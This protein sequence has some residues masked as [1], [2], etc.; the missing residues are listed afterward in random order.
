MLFLMDHVPKISQ[1]VPATN[2]PF[3]AVIAGQA[4]QLQAETN[5]VFFGKNIDGLDTELG[6]RR[7]M[8]MKD[9]YISML[10]S[11]VQTRRDTIGQIRAALNSRDTKKAEY[12]SHSLFGISGQIG[13]VRVPEDALQLESALSAIGEVNS[14]ELMESLL[15][16][17]EASFENL[18]TSLDAA[19]PPP[20]KDLIS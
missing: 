7:A 14:S 16:K 15:E 2:A 8:G 5:D 17:L 4:G 9:F 1:P 6:L 11:F 20:V 19:L 10:R 12:L 18:L 3:T 13:A